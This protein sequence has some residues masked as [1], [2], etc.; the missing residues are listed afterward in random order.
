MGEQAGAA[1]RTFS[2]GRNIVR[3]RGAAFASSFFWFFSIPFLCRPLWSEKQTSAST[4]KPSDCRETSIDPPGMSGMQ[5]QRVADRAGQERRGL[6]GGPG[7]VP[8]AVVR[9]Q[10]M[11]ALAD[12]HVEVALAFAAGR[13][14]HA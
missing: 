2:P 3:S 11:A 4:A 5:H 1:R 8:V 7:A 13:D 10:Q 14:G 12:G 9:G 6:A